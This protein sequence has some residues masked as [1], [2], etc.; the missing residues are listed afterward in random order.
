MTS[1]AAVHGQLRWTALGTAVGVAVPGLIA[2]LSTSAHAAVACDVAYTPG[3][4]TT[5]PGQG[6]F[7]A[8]VT[9]E[10]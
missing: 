6:G 5:S 9:V 2:G 3:T 7:T 1:R 8:D 4:W 10:R